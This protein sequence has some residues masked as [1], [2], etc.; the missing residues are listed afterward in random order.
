MKTFGLVLTNHLKENVVVYTLRLHR[1]E[2]KVNLWDTKQLRN[3][4]AKI[5]L[6]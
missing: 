3:K 5:K 6:V 2:T 1:S 4:V